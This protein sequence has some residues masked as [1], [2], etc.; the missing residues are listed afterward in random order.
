ME[1]YRKEATSKPV[2]CAELDIDGPHI[3]ISSNGRVKD[4]L[5]VFEKFLKQKES[6]IVISGVGMAVNKTVSVAEIIKRQYK[7]NAEI[8]IFDVAEIDVWNSVDGTL[9]PLEV[10]RH[11]PGIKCIIQT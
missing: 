11:L 5:I 1:N 3:R 6:P 4:Y 7:L 2:P 8:I 9:D 10:T